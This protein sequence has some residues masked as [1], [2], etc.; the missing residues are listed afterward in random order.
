MA[1]SCIGSPTSTFGTG[2]CADPV[3]PTLGVIA[4]TSPS[5]TLSGTSSPFGFVATLNTA[6]PLRVTGQLFGIS[7]GSCNITIAGPIQ[8]EGQLHF[9][10]S[11]PG[12]PMDQVAIG[13]I[14]S[15]THTV[16]PTSS[17][18][19]FSDIANLLSTLI[20]GIVG[21]VLVD[22]AQPVCQRNGSGVFEVCAV[23]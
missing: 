20:D 12:G 17:C 23:P 1:R 19:I 8:I 10:S 2:A 7:L 6:T 15:L 16:F 4:I 9:V 22:V 18:G 5:H 21:R 3:P 11:T 13:T 14:A